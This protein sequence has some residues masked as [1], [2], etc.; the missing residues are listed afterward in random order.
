MKSSREFTIIYAITDAV[1]LSGLVVFLMTYFDIRYLFNDTVVTGGDTASWMGVAH[2]LKSVLLPNGRLMGW[3]MGN[4]CGYPNFNFYFLPPFLLAVLPSTLFGFPLTITL[5][6]AI[7]SGIFLLPIATYV[8]LRFMGYRFPAPV[9]GTAGAVLFLFNE[10]YTMFGANN[11]STFAGEF[12]YMFAFSLF[13]LFIGTFYKGAGEN[14]WLVRNGIILGLI[15]LSHLFVFISALMLPLYSYF[16]GTRIRYLAGVG[17]IAF[18]CMAFWILPL[19]AFRHPY[20]T[21]VYMIWQDFVNI[22]YSMAGVLLLV[23]FI[24]PR[25]AIH[26]MSSK[27]ALALWIFSLFVG[28][29]A[30]A[31]AYLFGTYF[32]YGTDIWATG[33]HF[34]DPAHAVIGKDIAMKIRP[35]LLPISFGMGAAPVLM[36]YLLSKKR[37]FFVF[38]RGVAAVCLSVILFLG[39]LGLHFF[40][41]RKLT[42]TVLRN[43][44]LSVWFIGGVYGLSCAGCCM[45]W[46]VSG[47]FKRILIHLAGQL[48]AARFSLWIFLIFGCLVAYFSAHFLQVPDI[49]FLP[50]L[51]FALLMLLLVETV[52]PFVAVKGRFIRIMAGITLCYLV[53]VG[54]IFGAQQSGSWYRYNNKGYEKT[55]GYPE[56]SEV[57]E[58][59]QTVYQKEGLDPLNAPRVGYEKCDLYDRYGGDR[60]FESLRYF[61]GRQTLEG[62]HYAGS[63]AS[64]FV[65]FIQTEFSRD[66]KTPKPQILSKI[67]P[68]AL[69]IH[70][71]LYNI[72]QLVVMTDTMK[73]ALSG[74]PWFEKEAQFGNILLYRY[75]GCDGRYVDVPKVRPVLYTGRNWVDALFLWCKYPDFN[76]VLLVPEKFVKDPTDRAVFLDETDNVLELEMYRINKLD[77]K[78]LQIRTRIDDLQIRFSTNKPGVPHLVKV[79]YFPNWRVEGANGVY[80]VSPHLMLVIPRKD[81][82]TLT[83]AHSVWETVGLLITGIG[84]LLI[85][86]FVTLGRLK[87]SSKWMT[88]GIREKWDLLWKRIEHAGDFLRPYAFVIMVV[89][90]MILTVSGAFLRNRPVRTYIAG[91][92]AYK[93]GDFLRDEGKSGQAA[94]SYQQAISIMIPLLEDRSQYDHRDVINAILITAMCYE[95]LKDL[96]GAEAWYRTLLKEYPYSRYVAEANV[97]LARNYR[98]RSQQL[99]PAKLDSPGSGEEGQKIQLMEGLQWLDK[100]LM[101]YQRA[102]EDEPFSIWA[103]YAKNDLE[104]EQ[105]RLNKM[106]E[107]LPSL[108]IDEIVKKRMEYLTMKLRQLL[109]PEA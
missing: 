65:A 24:G 7:M 35:L 100:G 90:A 12:C 61:S 22:R 60:V 16:N 101:C 2:H 92:H 82:V 72:S 6:C 38:C 23:L 81:S 62:I 99:L 5:K 4:F 91:Y 40:V 63:I 8:G 67:N 95:N 46:I 106:T 25:F 21:P 74:F 109:I 103:Q 42:D 50:P 34:P 52:G 17:I 73:K 66:I 20:T 94:E 104:E 45:Y 75:I 31:A 28:L 102:L 55:A 59:L 84:A 18:V 54:I 33:L 97:K 56:F 37:L 69:P 70:F 108:T 85:I 29:G 9:I 49:R 14:R 10:T 44:L 1:L 47:N 43:D 83:Y 107:N 93:K 64:R 80:P 87:V 86:G 48:P 79:S 78:N 76:D 58:Y 13:V 39:L 53:M 71:D 89:T 11:L 51:S 68:D 77:R 41:V 15:G 105:K 26:S 27:S 3:D 30:F 98:I 32:V 36:G 57:S 19:V 96:D 88:I